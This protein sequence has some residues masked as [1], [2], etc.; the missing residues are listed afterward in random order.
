MPIEMCEWT[1]NGCPLPPL[2]EV[3]KV[4]GVPRVNKDGLLKIDCS[5]DTSPV[6]T[7][8][9]KSVRIDDIREKYFGGLSCRPN[10]GKQGCKPIY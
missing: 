6:Y 1:S 4:V 9:D 8:S 10:G 2:N 7:S 3:V 5:Y